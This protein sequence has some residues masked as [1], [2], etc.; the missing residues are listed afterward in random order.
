MAQDQNA[1]Q[2]GVEALLNALDSISPEASITETIS[3]DY[4]LSPE[5]QQK[6]IDTESLLREALALFGIDYNA[7]VRMDSSSVYAQA[8]QASPEVAR[9]VAESDNPVMEALKI[10]AYFKPYAEFQNRYGRTPDEIKASLR[11]EFEEEAAQT[12]APA[13]K[14]AAPVEAPLFSRRAYGSKPTAKTT[15]RPAVGDL[16]AFIKR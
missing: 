5:V 6:I 9:R 8:I 7:L 16:R 1:P 2:N 3:D 10:A 14:A 11:R 13:E 12:T 15:A 4:D